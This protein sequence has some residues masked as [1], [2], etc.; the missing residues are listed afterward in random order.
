[1]IKRLKYGKKKSP[2]NLVKD[3]TLQEWNKVYSIIQLKVIRN[4]DDPQNILVDSWGTNC[5]FVTMWD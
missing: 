1:M 4:P 2:H 3:A 5:G